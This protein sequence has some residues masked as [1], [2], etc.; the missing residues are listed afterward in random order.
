MNPIRTILI[1]V[2]VLIF[3]HFAWASGAE[4][5]QGYQQ[6]DDESNSFVRLVQSQPMI[7]A[8]FYEGTPGDLDGAF[9]EA[10]KTP[11]FR[12]AEIQFIK[13]ELSQTGIVEALQKY[14]V[15]QQDLPMIVLFRDGKIV[16]DDSGKV[17]GLMGSAT[18][19]EVR[20]FV[21][22]YFSDQIQGVMKY[23]KENPENFSERP[24]DDV[25]YAS[26]SEGYPPSLNY[27]PIIYQ[28]YYSWREPFWWS[29]FYGSSYYLPYWRGYRPFYGF[30]HRPPWYHH[31]R[32]HHWDD[33]RAHR[34]NWHHDGPH[35]RHGVRHYA[36]HDGHRT[37]QGAQTFAQGQHIEPRSFGD[38]GF[39]DLGSR[40]TR[41]Q[42]RNTSYRRFQGQPQGATNLGI[43]SYSP[44][45]GR[46]TLGQQGFQQQLQN[47]SRR[48][49]G[50]QSGFQQG[51]LRS[52]QL[53][54]TIQTRSFSNFS[55]RQS[56]SS[57]PR[58]LRSGGS[59]GGRR[60]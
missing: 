35:D 54:Q 10:S 25:L 51:F 7:V 48:Y 34:R 43:T 16:M 49:Q 15:N 11:R 19:D 12:F 41:Y 29:G 59:S 53:Q 26:S 47:F 46:F 36:R 9:L 17:V 30:Y 38:R 37:W 4:M 18:S 13:A 44:R 42:A 60:R 3:A 8:L 27:Q 24:S 28:P 45:R 33:R 32:P 5:P 6:M 58:F 22:D 1:L 2:H 39:T 31:H 52:S 55:N 50:H 57:S 40:A 14:G 56:S 21:D 20:N 23:S